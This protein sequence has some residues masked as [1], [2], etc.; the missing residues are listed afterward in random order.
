MYSPHRKG[1]TKS[2][3]IN[4]VAVRADIPK[5][6][7]TLAVNAVFD[8]IEETVAESDKVSIPGFGTFERKHKEARTV[9]NPQTGES[10]VSEAKNVPAFNLTRFGSLYMG[11]SPHNKF[12]LYPFTAFKLYHTVLDLFNRSHSSPILSPGLA[13]IGFKIS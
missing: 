5:T 4:I 3:L 8:A 2:E 10:M 13:L 7:A 12:H 6:K 1:A 11:L 9:R